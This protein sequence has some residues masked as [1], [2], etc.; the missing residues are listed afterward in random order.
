MYSNSFKKFQRIVIHN[1]QIHKVEFKYKN[2]FGRLTIY[3]KCG[4]LIETHK[5][6]TEELDEKYSFNSTIL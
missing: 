3:N 4:E 6:K 5:I 1:D 2:E